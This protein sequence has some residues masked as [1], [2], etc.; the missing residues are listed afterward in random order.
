M[1]Q[2]GFRATR[3]EF[4]Q[5]RWMN[6][7]AARFDWFT[8]ACRFE[9]SSGRCFRCQTGCRDWAK[10]ANGREETCAFCAEHQQVLFADLFAGADTSEDTVVAEACNH[11]NCLVLPFRLE[12]I[13]L[14]T[15]PV[16]KVIGW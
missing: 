11:P 14:A 8:T 7:S 10:C 4:R 16:Y 5:E 12:L 3:I 2:Q 6:D 13:R 1:R 15:Q 9:C